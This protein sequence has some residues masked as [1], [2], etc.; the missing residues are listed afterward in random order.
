VLPGINDILPSSISNAI[1][2]YLPSSAG[3]AIAS[4]VPDAHTL[5]PW[6]GFAVYCGYTLALLALAA[7]LLVRRDA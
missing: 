2:P 5:S 7:Y 3:A 6:V 1:N 4:A